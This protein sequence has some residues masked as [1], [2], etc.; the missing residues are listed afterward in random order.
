MR[1]LHYEFAAEA[2]HRLAKL[3]PVRNE[4][5]AVD[6]R[7]AGDNAT[8]HSHRHIGRDDGAD[9]ALG[10]FAFPIYPRL[11][12]GTVFVVEPAGYAGPEDS[13]LDL[14]IVEFQWRENHVL[15]GGRG[16]ALGGG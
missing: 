4:V 3:L 11:G 2:V 14:K 9:A 16:N 15:S 1:Q 8:L 12:E 5:V 10:E 13:V 6:G 7:V